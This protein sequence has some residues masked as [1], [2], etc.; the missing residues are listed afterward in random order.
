MTDQDQGWT[1]QLS[2]DG[3]FY[4]SPRCGG[5][6]F[7]RREWFDMATRKAEELA[8]RMGDG[9][10]PDVWENLGWHYSVRKGTA[11]IYP[12]EDR[13][14]GFDPEHGFGVRSYM[15]MVNVPATVGGNGG[16]AVQFIAHAAQPEDALGFAVQD[17]RTV[18]RRIADALAEIAGAG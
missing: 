3:V 16:T 2:P 12:S 6:R 18:E 4:C 13:N 17:G 8:R 1:P 5:G 11:R 7:C 14:K 15:A 10:T 9:W